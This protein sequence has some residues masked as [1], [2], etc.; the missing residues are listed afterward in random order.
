MGPAKKL[1]K[2]VYTVSNK[3]M[4][5]R[6]YK[7]IWLLAKTISRRLYTVMAFFIILNICIYAAARLLHP[8]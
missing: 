7:Q 3:N 2:H 8:I 6:T 4:R 5:V 1:Y